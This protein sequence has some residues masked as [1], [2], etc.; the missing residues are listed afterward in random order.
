MTSARYGPEF[1]SVWVASLWDVSK[2][3]FI[4]KGQC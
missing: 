1:E 3:G 2:V 4:D